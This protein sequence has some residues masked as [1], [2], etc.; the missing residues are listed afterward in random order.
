MFHNKVLSK[1]QDFSGRATIRAEGQNLGFNE[2]AIPRDM[3]W[4]MYKF[5]ILR[6]LSKKGYDYVNSEKAWTERSPA[7]VASFT[8][9]TKSIPV[10]LNRAPTLMK[11]N[12]T[13]VYPIPI[14]GNTIGLNPLH[15]PM[16][17]GDFDG[18]AQNLYVPMTAEAIN[19]AKEKLLPQVQIN[20]YRRGLNQSLI[21]PA[22][23][24]ILGSVHMT[25]PDMSQRV[26]HFKSEEACLKA[27]SAG[28]IKENT[29]VEI[30]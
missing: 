3:L 5:H 24:A 23:E 17:A 1:K 10:I 15:L 27:L 11:S 12:I 18:D 13:A 28:E 6:D 20:D 9:M 2:A 29:P 8:K 4:T 22:H 30:G 25:E 7:A 26:V 16:F 21:A 19:E 14:D